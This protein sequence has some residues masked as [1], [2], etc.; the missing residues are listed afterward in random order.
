MGEKL[1]IARFEDL[2]LGSIAKSKFS[3]SVVG[4][5][6]ETGE[7]LSCRRS[8]SLPPG[9][10]WWYGCIH[11]YIPTYRCLLSYLCIY[12]GLAASSFNSASWLARSDS[13]FSDVKKR[14]NEKE[15]KFPKIWQ[16]RYCGKNPL[17]LNIFHKKLG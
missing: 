17:H 16:L 10:S 6:E 12:A 2:R 5:Q 11:T 13:R 7:T 14:E 4:P 9:C 8:F 3:I 1:L 15:R